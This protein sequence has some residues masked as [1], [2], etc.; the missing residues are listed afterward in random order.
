MTIY[1]F[2]EGFAWGAATASYQI[3]GAYD[4]DGRGL[5]IW[6]TFSHTPGKVKN[7][8][9]GDVACDSYHRYKEDVQLL[10]ELGVSTYRFSIAWPRIYPK[11]RGEANRL[12]LDYYHRLVDELLANGIEP[13]CTLYHW[14]LPQAL[15]DEGGWN[16]RGT[17]D[18][19]VA[20][21][22]TMF[23]EFGGKIKKWITFNE[24]W[25]SSFLSN[26]L[27]IHAPG[28][29]DL[30]LATNIAHHILVAHGR[31]VS[32][33]RKLGAEGI[34]GIAPNMTWAVPYGP[35]E[36]DRKACLRNIQWTGDWFKDPIFFGKYP[37]EL[38][39]CIEGAG[40]TIPILDGDMEDIRQPIDFLGLNYYSAS[41]N[42]Y[43]PEAGLLK[44]EPIESHYEKSDIG[45]PYDAVGF[46]DS[47]R[48]VKDKYGDIPIYITE[49]GA[50]INDAP[51]LDGRVRDDRRI[52]YYKQHLVSLSRAIDAGVNVVG[53]MAWSLLDN[54][55]WAEG[56]D[57][58]F[59]L[60]YVD[61]R[62]LK[63]TKKD[64]Y[65]W[66]EKVARNNWFEVK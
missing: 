46:Y 39:E 22:E 17:I 38:R 23:K 8:D 65:Y 31:T 33:F 16:N 58:R 21:A 9:N 28:N 61:F 12:G 52:D 11:G 29:K 24:P 54:F 42:R 32:L 55:E 41:I 5:S 6:D 44:S 18:A 66:Y 3:E 25:C 19:F 37:D 53:Y 60:V 36:E 14:D 40:A 34:I 56:Y 48:Y 57:M 10:K 13:F 20:F 64:S 15:E 49:N 43:N 51:G 27:G 1:R 26:Y 7:G 63:R 62:T 4:E 50:C 35:S 2:K 59:G 45:W 30:Q 47:L